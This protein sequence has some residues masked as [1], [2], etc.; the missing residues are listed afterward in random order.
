MCVWENWNIGK[1][2][3]VCKVRGEEETAETLENY[4]SRNIKS[5]VEYN[6]LTAYQV[7]GISSVTSG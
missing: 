5:N 2:V 3:C 1:F 7:L 4:T 6:M